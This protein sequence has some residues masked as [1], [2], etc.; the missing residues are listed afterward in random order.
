MNKATHADLQTSVRRKK[1]VTFS[2]VTGSKVDAGL[3]FSFVGV[4]VASALAANT[5][6]TFK[7]G[8]GAD[9]AIAEPSAFG[10]VYVENSDG[11]AAAAYTILVD[12]DTGYFPLDPG[13]FNGCRWLQPI[14]SEDNDTLTI[15]LIA[16][17]V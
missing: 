14:S 5:E 12:T 11:S 15:T 10:A 9:E 7:K 17:P 16:K 8:L 2:T 1:T 6:L 4:E 13:V 3:G